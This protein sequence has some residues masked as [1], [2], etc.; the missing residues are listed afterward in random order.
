MRPLCVSL[1]LLFAAAAGADVLVFTHHVSDYDAKPAAKDNTAA[2]QKALDAAYK[3]GGGIVYAP[4]GRY[5]FK[6]GLA[7]PPGV[8]LRGDWS[9]SGKGKQTVLCV[10]ADRGNEKG[11]PFIRMPNS[12]CL[13]D[14]TLWYP[15]QEAG[16]IQP[17]PWTIALTR[18]QTPLFRGHAFCTMV[19][20][21]TLVNSYRGILVDFGHLHF[22]KH[23]YGTPL[24][25][26]I[27]V[28]MCSD[29]GRLAECHFDASQ[30]EQ[31]G[32]PGSPA[33]DAGR[34]KLRRFLL[35]RGTAFTV[36][37]SDTEVLTNLG[38]TGYR[39]GLRLVGFRNFSGR[40]RRP[41][42][43]NSYGQAYGLTMLDCRRALQI[44]S[45]QN[46]VGYEISASRFTASDRCVSGTGNAGVQFNSCAFKAGPKGVCVEGPARHESR[47]ELTFQNCT[48]EDWETA[49]LTAQNGLLSVV[50]CKFKADKK[51]A[52]VSPGVRGVLFARNRFESKTP[53][54]ENKCKTS[55][56]DHAP[57]A[58]SIP[59]A[60]PYKYA[61]VPQPASTR[62][63]NVREKPYA[64]AGDGKANDT[65]AIQ[66]ALDT[67][68]ETGGTCFLPAGKYRIDGAL[69]VPPGVELR[70]I[71]DGCARP[72]PNTAGTLLLAHRDK[73]KPDAPPLITLGAK[74][75][76]RGIA[77][78][79]PEQNNHRTVTKYPWVVRARGA[80]CYVVSVCLMNPYRGI[81]I[82]G[83][84]HLVSNLYMTTLGVGLRIGK[85]KGGI[86]EDYH[87]HPQFWGLQ[88]VAGYGLPNHKESIGCMSRH[89]TCMIL[90]DCQDET[91]VN[92]STWKALDG[93][94]FAS[95]NCTARIINATFDQVRI[96][97]AIGAAK[98][99]SAINTQ[100]GYLCVQ[101]GN[102][103]DG[104][105]S[106]FNSVWRG[107]AFPLDLRGP[108]TALMQQDRFKSGGA[109]SLRGGRLRMEGG[110]H[111]VRAWRLED[112][113]K[114]VEM[115]GTMLA[116]PLPEDKRMRGTQTLRVP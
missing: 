62:V 39:Y 15:Q 32:L 51:I 21:V 48:F 9:R 88:V 16:D 12:C 96:C 42:R 19:R 11:T 98:S 27:D 78:L 47:G 60:P 57:L 7:I 63:L 8:T 90:G 61:A 38:A 4:A 50:Q 1:L 66:K 3:D 13:R 44:D 31:S 113:T 56:I 110:I 106:F 10:F 116:A 53:L 2:F 91:I 36:A 80:E 107:G 65:A 94:R 23:V 5:A 93:L 54:I 112:K 26:G 25:E 76:L 68:K 20:N 67:L 37:Y 97:Y 49:A 29:V 102:A 70:G 74:S 100:G 72:A 105:A 55:L 86:V 99:I 79:H 58:L 101:T 83:D 33:T 59:D 82:A 30:W 89:G 40:K 114:A 28:D 84:R 87:A 95:K 104:T 41:P 46:Q 18:L 64:A 52:D 43:S 71:W 17:Y 85:S 77:V 73:G 6:G 115:T 103:F 81:D 75:G 109:H 69:A 108:G 45:V 34:A 92:F 35:D 22:I 24:L 111:R 14:L